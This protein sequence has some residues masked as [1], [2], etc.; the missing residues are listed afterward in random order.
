MSV[1]EAINSFNSKFVPGFSVGDSLVDSYSRYV[2]ASTEERVKNPTFFDVLNNMFT[3][4][5][6]FQR[7]QYSANQAYN[8]SNAQ[9]LQKYELD[10]QSL[11]EQRAWEEYMSNTAY[12]RAI[13]DLRNAGINPYAIASFSPASTPSTG[14]ASASQGSGYTGSYSRYGIQLSDILSFA[15]SA[16]GFARSL[17]S[18]ASVKAYNR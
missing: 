14:Y 18:L 7:Q 3:G 12:S 5:L 1:Q 17:T 8:M 9:M 4:N 11:K 16:L 13:S 15:S 6:D 2:N 10:R